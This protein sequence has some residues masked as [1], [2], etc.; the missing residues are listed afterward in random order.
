MFHPHPGRTASLAIL[1]FAV[2]AFNAD[3]A[4]AETIG[5]SVVGPSP[6]FNQSIYAGAMIT[7][8]EN[9]VT[10]RLANN[11]G[12]PSSINQALSGLAL[13]FS[14][15]QTVGSLTSSSGLEQYIGVGTST[16][17]GVGPSGWLLMNN[18]GGGIQLCVA[19]GSVGP[20]RTIIHQ[21]YTHNF[22]DGTIAGSSVN[23]TFLVGDVT[24]V[25]YV[26]GV[27]SGT[28]VTSA[29]F[30]FGTV[31]QRRLTAYP[32]APSPEPAT[33]LLLGTGVAGVALRIRKR[34]RAGRES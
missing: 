11:L 31:D 24:F 10:I 32:A 19:C 28:Y 23:N 29:T 13:T 14:T 8:S 18:V 33:L 9:M 22:L 21:S 30:T 26:P 12:N 16:N 2:L 4:K 7:T 6:I 3:A 1:V 5:I 34:R 25:L 20:A 17:I 15:G 27:T